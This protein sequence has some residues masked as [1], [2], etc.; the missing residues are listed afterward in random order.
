MVRGER[1]TFAKKMWS[2]SPTCQDIAHSLVE[3]SEKESLQGMRKDFRYWKLE[4]LRDKADVQK[5]LFESLQSWKC[6]L[7]DACLASPHR[8]GSAVL[9]KCCLKAACPEY[10]R[11]SSEP[12]SC[13]LGNKLAENSEP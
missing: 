11:Y 9:M 10:V 2:S 13:R 3:K 6:T 1:V 5:A 12:P 7:G 8:V 4:C